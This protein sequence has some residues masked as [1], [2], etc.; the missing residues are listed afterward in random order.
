MK[1]GRVSVLQAFVANGGVRNA[2]KA[3]TYLA[4]WGAVYRRYRRAPTV[5]EYCEFWKQSRATTYRESLA[6]S[7]CSPDLSVEQVWRSLPSAVRRSSDR[8][9]LIADV[10]SAKWVRS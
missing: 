8:S 10:A 7:K 6:F 2:F 5:E 3:A 4:S 1:L 9:A